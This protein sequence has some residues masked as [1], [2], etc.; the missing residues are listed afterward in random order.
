MKKCLDTGWISS[1]G[2]YVKT[3]ERNFSKY[4]GK[5]Y[6]NAGFKLVK[7]KFDIK[8]TIKEHEKIYLNM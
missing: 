8:K 7:E 3:F 2:S 6:G 5:K 4:I 1:E